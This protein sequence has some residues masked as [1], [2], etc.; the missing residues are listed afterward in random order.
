MRHLQHSD[1]AARQRVSGS[2]L[3]GE[4]LVAT[5]LTDYTVGAG[6]AGRAGDV[7]VAVY[8]LEQYGRGG[9]I[10]DC[11]RAQG[12]SLPSLGSLPI[13][14]SI[15]GSSSSALTAP[16]RSALATPERTALVPALAAPASALTLPASA[17]ALPA[18]HAL[19]A[20]VRGSARERQSEGAHCAGADT[21]LGAHKK[22]VDR[23]AGAGG[24]LARGEA[25]GEASGTAG[26]A[27]AEQE[28]HVDRRESVRVVDRDGAGGVLLAFLATGHNNAEVRPNRLEPPAFRLPAWRPAAASGL[29]SE[30]WA[31]AS[32]L[33]QLLTA[34]AEAAEQVWGQG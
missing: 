16:A 8:R 30:A 32:L 29:V 11:D 6:E 21:R 22:L 18:R 20:P 15:P 33:L 12:G 14:S 23:V 27:L 34:L 19:A 4:V 24:A 5:R 17:L 7:V 13:C 28:Q 10:D 3:V 31:F 26:Y 2:L 1:L 25:G 9:Y